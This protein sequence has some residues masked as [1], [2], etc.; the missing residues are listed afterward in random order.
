M[1]SC[2]PG[3]WRNDPV[4][5]G[6]RW[7]RAGSPIAGAVGATYRLVKTDEGRRI[8]CRVT[9]SNPPGSTVAT[10]APVIPAAPDRTT[11]AMRI[12]GERLRMS[13]AGVVKVRLTCPGNET[14]CS[15]TVLLRAVEEKGK[16]LLAVRGFALGG[17]KTRSF[18][19]QLDDDAQALVRKREELPVRVQAN[20][21]DA[22]GNAARIRRKLP[23]SAD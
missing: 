22:V 7:L 1:V 23:L 9:A 15:G 21:R 11:P 20:A 19:L 16:P 3:S 4:S 14:R 10:S 12:R 18:G 17:G 2:A 6:F 8:A 5:F 13:D